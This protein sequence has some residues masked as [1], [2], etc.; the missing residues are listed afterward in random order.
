MSL[1]AINGIGIDFGGIRALDAVSLSV[2]QG[3]V[4][5]IIGPNGA[6]KTTLFNV[7]TGVYTPHR[8]SIL[9]DGADVT[10]VTPWRLAR[11]GLSRS[12]QN[13]QIFGRMSVLDNVMVGRHRHENRNMLAHLFTLPSVLAQN[14][15]SREAALHYLKYVQLDIDPRRPAAALSYGELKRME[16]ARALATEPR[17]LLLDEPAAGCN[18]TETDALSGVI[19][20]IADDGI[21]VVLIEHDM[22]LVVQISDRIHVLNQ[23]STL[24]QGKGAEV[25][26]RPEVMAAYLGQHGT[27]EM[28]RA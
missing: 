26:S 19:R 28:L 25:M 24:A 2:G 12:F 17:I 27:Q 16:I 20:K 13:L 4:F 11:A 8:G 5:S 10:G 18:P 9:L 22:K 3:E 7:I 6:G 15:A 21:T 1:L 14:R 23:G